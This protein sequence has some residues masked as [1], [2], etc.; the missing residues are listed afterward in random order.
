MI[1]NFDQVIDRRG[2][3]SLKYDFMVERGKPEDTIPMWVADMDFAAPPEVLEDIKNAVYHGVFGYTEPKDEYYQA[4]S[5]WYNSRFHYHVTQLETIIAPGVVYSLAQ[6]IRALTNS[7]DAIMVQT[8]VYY[9]FYNIITGNGRKLVSNPLVYEK[10]K[11]SIDFLDFERKIS[12]NDV[13]MF[14]LCSP[15]NPVGRVWTW[16]ELEIM[17]DI[18]ENNGVIVVSDEIHCD[19]VW[20]GHEHNCIATLNENAIVTASP[21]KTFN[22][23]GLQVS[24]IFVKNAQYRETLKAE[25][26]KSGYT[27]YNMLGLIAAQSAY[28]KGLDWLEQLKT[29]LAENISFTREYLK[30]KL[31]MIRLVE[32]ES[33][34][35]LWLDFSGVEQEQ[36]VLEKRLTEGAR[37]WMNNGEMFGE[38]GKG[39]F[40]LNVACPMSTLREALERLE[41]EFG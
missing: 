7:K 27:Q 41:K 38:E 2:T 29:Y 1:Y 16:E 3:N 26:E 18:C 20:E 32:P 5:N 22:L 30:S 33:T 34:Y 37:I 11:Y 14:I 6:T 4:V 9:P 35:L 15:H 28:T 39:F 31:P 40:R 23:A 25:I 8:P 10:G 13:R 36:E 12:E 17:S 21:S 19:F 24:N